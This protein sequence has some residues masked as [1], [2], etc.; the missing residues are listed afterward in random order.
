MMR[1]SA[2]AVAT[3]LVVL[4]CSADRDGTLQS[5]LSVLETLARADTA[6]YA[7]ALE[8]RAFDFPADHGP[9]PEFRTEWWY[10]TGNLTSGDE[11]PRDFGFQ[12]TIFRSALAP[13]EPRSPSAW[14]THQA[15]MAHF[16]VTDVAAGAFH[17]HER[18]ARAVQPYRCVVRGDLRL[19]RV[20]P[21]RDAIEVHAQERLRV[22]GLQRLEEVADAGAALPPE[23]VVVGR[24]CGRVGGR[25]DRLVR[26]RLRAAAPEVIGD[27]SAQHPVEPGGR[28]FL[29]AHGG[30]PLDPPDERILEDVLRDLAG[31]HTSLQEAQEARV[32]VHQDLDDLVAACVRRGFGHF[33]GLA[34]NGGRVRG[35]RGPRTAGYQQ[36]PPPQEQSSPQ[37]QQRAVF[38]AIQLIVSLLAWGRGAAHAAAL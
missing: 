27:R 31:P 18:F 23:L 38:S 8:P 32:V 29:L 3:G 11:P 19:D 1:A 17:A 26:P 34:V 24:R 6:G 16:T 36:Q 21:Y 25:E 5:R 9:H 28:R 4:A 12:L 35:P 10:V 2:T 22:F 13:D 7:R 14:A 37:S 30:G 15:Y 33:K 20:V